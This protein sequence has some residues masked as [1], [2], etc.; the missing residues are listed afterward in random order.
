[1]TFLIKYWRELLYCL[2]AG[3]VTFGLLTLGAYIG[4]FKYELRVNAAVQEKDKAVQEKDKAVQELKDYQA[5]TEKANREAEATL[6]LLQK[7]NDLLKVEFKAKVDAINAK[8]NQ[9][10]KENEATYSRLL[11]DA[12]LGVFDCNEGSGEGGE[13][14][15]QRLRLGE[16]SAQRCR[17]P[18]ATRRNLIKL[19]KDAQDVVVQYNE[20]VDKVNSIP[21]EAK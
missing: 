9:Q 14:A 5:L 4:S 8:H 21:K 11:N 20:L 12:T 6:K 19:A 10:R 17:L 2:L 7:E 15:L 13:Y 3:A 16:S 18:E 1:M